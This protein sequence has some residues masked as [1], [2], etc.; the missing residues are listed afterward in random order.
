MRQLILLLCLAATWLLW[1]GIFT[2][3]L[4]ITGVLCCLLVLILAWRMGFFSEDV[5]SLHI[6]H[7][8]P[9]YWLWLFW[10]LV[11]S[12]LEVTRIVLSP[13]LRVRPKLVTVDARPLSPVGIAI[14]GNSITLTPGTVTLAIDGSTLYVHCLTA[15]T[16]NSLLRGDL[17]RHI[18]D[19]MHD[20]EKI[21]DTSTPQAPER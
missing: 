18:Q 12:N 8:L 3:Q 7:R 19:L 13:R 10:Q 5:F 16:A 11:L 6:L 2:T 4:L 1:S 14:F 21:P 17:K 15:H 20:Y 9:R